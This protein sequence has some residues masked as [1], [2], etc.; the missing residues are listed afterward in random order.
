M[1]HHYSVNKITEK[2][3]TITKIEKLEEEARIEEIA[4]LLSGETDEV[5][6]VHAAALFAKQK[7]SNP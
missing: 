1:D 6:R 2:G 5:A 3:R 4:R 7:G